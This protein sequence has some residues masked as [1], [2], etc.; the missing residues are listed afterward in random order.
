MEKRPSIHL[1]KMEKKEKEQKKVEGDRRRRRTEKRSGSFFSGHC[2][3]LLVAFST[4]QLIRISH[5][6]LM[7][8]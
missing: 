3:A 8:L 5:V 7:Q 1:R 4:D 2:L 6:I